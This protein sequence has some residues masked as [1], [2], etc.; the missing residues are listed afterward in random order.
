[1]ILGESAFV[2][3]MVPFYREYEPVLGET[4]EAILGWT[5]V[6]SKNKLKNHVNVF[7]SDREYE[8]EFFNHLKTFCSTKGTLNMKTIFNKDSNVFKFAQKVTT[9]KLIDF[10]QGKI[11]F[12]IQRVRI[13]VCLVNSSDELDVAAFKTD[14]KYHELKEAEFIN[15]VNGSFK[16]TRE[17]EKM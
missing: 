3:K 4:H 16:V 6:I 15:E 13:D 5:K 8:S 7:F 11:F 9:T 14:K 2:Y 17:V 1:M 10:L 12:S